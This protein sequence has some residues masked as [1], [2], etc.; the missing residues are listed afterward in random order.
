MPFTAV[1]KAKS[2]ELEKDVDIE[3]IREKLS[4]RFG[5]DIYD[6]S[7]RTP[8]ASRSSQSLRKNSGAPEEDLQTM[9]Q[10]LSNKFKRIRLPTLCGYTYR[11]TTSFRS[12][13]VAE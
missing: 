13:D 4:K 6:Y 7:S 11:R 12:K 3:A 2:V 5:K 10:K 1:K 9:K 8:A